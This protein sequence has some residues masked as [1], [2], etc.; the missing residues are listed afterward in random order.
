MGNFFVVACR[1]AWKMRRFSRPIVRQWTARRF[2]ATAVGSQLIPMVNSLQSVFAQAKQDFDL[3]QI[4]VVG[5]QSSG[6]SSVIETLVGKDFL[7]RGRGIVT[8]VPLVLQLLQ[9]ENREMF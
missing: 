9:S 1:V 3:P 6:K 2:Q 4:V 8:R 5:S 7:P